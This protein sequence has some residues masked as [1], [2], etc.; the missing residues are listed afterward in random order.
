MDLQ[1]TEMK[2]FQ[3]QLATKSAKL[4][5]LSAK[6]MKQTIDVSSLKSQSSATTTVADDVRLVAGA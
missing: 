2:A 1:D 4:L 6:H 5:Q 3:K